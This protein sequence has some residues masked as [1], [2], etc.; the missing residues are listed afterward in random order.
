MQRDSNG[1]IVAHWRPFSRELEI[2]TDILEYLQGR[3][4]L[5]ADALSRGDNIYCKTRDAIKDKQAM[6]RRVL[7]L[8]LQARSDRQWQTGKKSGRLDQVRIVSALQGAENVYRKR[9]DGRA[10]DSLLHMAVDASGSMSGNNMRSAMQLGIALSDALERTGCDIS[11]DVWGDYF[12]SNMPAARRAVLE[13]IQQRVCQDWNAINGYG[14][15]FTSIGSVENIVI[16]RV[17]DRMT[18]A[19]SR[20]RIGLMPS[21]VHGGTPGWEALFS[22][23]RKV[24]KCKQS[25]KILLFVTDGEFTH[26]RNAVWSA[27]AVALARSLDVHM[28]G[29][30][31]E[32]CDVSHIFSDAISV[33]SSAMY[34]VVMKRLAKYIAQEKTGL[35]RA[36]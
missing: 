10:M 24:G 16:K 33:S 25:K 29:V 5:E 4:V 31:I 35:M 27:D 20:A 6:I 12:R 26:G 34:E 30:G 17:T 18:N 22:A 11:I 28:V 8:E 14:A 36:A 21:A 23:I 13:P 1:N 9:E 19:I 3:G 2:E 32:G 15:G 7:E